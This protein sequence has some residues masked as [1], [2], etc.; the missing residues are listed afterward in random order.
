[1][2]YFSKCSQIYKS[3][4]TRKL[5]T[6]PLFFTG[7]NHQKDYLSCSGFGLP[8]DG[9]RGLK[10]GIAISRKMRLALF[11]IPLIWPG[12]FIIQTRTLRSDVYFINPELRPL[13]SHQPPHLLFQV[14]SC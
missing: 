6:P 13:D 8:A 10:G 9:T 11:H 4:E 1:M 3:R 12:A 14:R 5:P 2:I 7:A